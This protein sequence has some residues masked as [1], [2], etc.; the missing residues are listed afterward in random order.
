MCCSFALLISV[1]LVPTVVAK[2]EPPSIAVVKT[3]AELQAQPAI[4]LGAGVKI[5]LGLE[6][7]R[8][9]QWSGGLLYCLVEGYTPASSGEGTPLGPVLADFTF[10]DDK[11]A[12]LAGKGEWKAGE[13]ENPKGTYL[14]VRALP[15]DRIG[16]YHATVTSPDGKV[17]ATTAVEGTKDF[18]HPWM[19]WLKGYENY[20]APHEEGIVLPGLPTLAPA[21]FLQMGKVYKGELPTYLPDPCKPTLTIEKLSKKIV[22]R[23][24]TKFTTSHPEINFLARWWVNGKPFVPRQTDKFWIYNGSGRV[25]EEN[26]LQVEIEFRPA[27]LGAK[28][29]DKISLQLMHCECGW[30]WCREEHLGKATESRKYSEN[31]RVSNRIEFEVPK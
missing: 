24:K 31:I 25:S 30:T 26:E 4:D 29:G 10:S 28:P 21:L 27:R 7:N 9:P 19:P 22:V 11:L 8:M 3:W 17:L 18:F 13:K 23:A 14:Y 2:A 20:V 12:N 1:L 5:R 16:T 6:A 15:I